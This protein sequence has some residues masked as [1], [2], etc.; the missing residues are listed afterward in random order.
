MPDKQDQ[1]KVALA[2]EL[3][4]MCDTPGWKWV[5]RELKDEEGRIIE[6]WVDMPDDALTSKKAYAFKGRLRA[7][8]TVFDFVESAI[9]EGDSIGS[10]SV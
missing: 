2:N 9:R 3:R 8:R 5:I 6:K 1:R 10:D 4:A 7:I